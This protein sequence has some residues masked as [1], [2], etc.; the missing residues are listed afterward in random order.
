MHHQSTHFK[1]FIK[2]FT[3]KHQHVT[4]HSREPC[5]HSMVGHPIKRAAVPNFQEHTYASSKF[6]FKLMP[7][8]TS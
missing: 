6:T 1:T 5:V 7:N 3:K 2:L 4:V 8:A